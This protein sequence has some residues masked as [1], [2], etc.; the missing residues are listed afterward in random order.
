MTS[1]SAICGW[2]GDEVLP[3]GRTTSLTFESA[4][5]PPFLFPKFNRRLHSK[6]SYLN[7]HR[8]DHILTSDHQDSPKFFSQKRGI[9]NL[10]P[11]KKTIPT[12]SCRLPGPGNP[13]TPSWW[14]PLTTRASPILRPEVMFISRWSWV[15][16]L[17]SN[18]GVFPNKRHGDFL[19]GFPT[20]ND[21]HFWGVWNGGSTKKRKTAI[22]YKNGFHSTIWGFQTHMMFV[23][24]SGRRW[25][26]HLW[27]ELRRKRT[28]TIWA[29]I[30]RPI[31]AITRGQTVVD[32]K[33][34][35]DR[36]DHERK[37]GIFW[38]RHTSK[39]GLQRNSPKQ[40]GESMG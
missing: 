4:N 32:W 7:I 2:F 17:A 34:G 26:Y 18:A 16:F 11:N 37:L 31:E 1:Q 23:L 40:N 14:Y 13:G 38:T 33:N 12:W 19:V 25:L 20:E 22:I 27:L 28:I 36:A 30:C 15:E 39:I 21:Q 10:S 35:R 9:S 6:L 29:P 5:G 24:F 8:S 3:F